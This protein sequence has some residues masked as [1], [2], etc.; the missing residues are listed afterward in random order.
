MLRVG[1]TRT[2]VVP[3]TTGHR[4]VEEPGVFGA[5]AQS[6]ADLFQVVQQ[7]PLCHSRSVRDIARGEGG[8]AHLSAAA[9]SLVSRLPICL[10]MK[11]GMEVWMRSLT[12]VGPTPSQKISTRDSVRH[13]I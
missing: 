8:A 5:P 9:T 12:S 1:E 13:A 3:S 4:A 7:F 6:E 2:E 10:V 11:D